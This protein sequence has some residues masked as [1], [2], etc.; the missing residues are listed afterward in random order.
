MIPRVLR[1]PHNPHLWKISTFQQLQP[2]A[3]RKSK[4]QP[5]M[6]H[7]SNWQQEHQTNSPSRL[8]ALRRTLADSATVQRALLQPLQIR[9]LLLLVEMTSRS[10]NRRRR[11]HKLPYS[12]RKHLPNLILRLLAR[13]RSSIGSTLG[14]QAFLIS[15]PMQT[16]LYPT[17]NRSRDQMHRSEI[18]T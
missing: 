17:S 14:S 9:N 10:R 12:P 18:R 8:M 13:E 4:S 2:R 6:K 11:A 7:P 16:R 3:K 5:M 15:N 1:N